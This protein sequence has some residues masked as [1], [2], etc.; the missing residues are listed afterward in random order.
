MPELRKISG[1]QALHTL[2]RLGFRRVRQRGS[3]VVLTKHTPQGKVG[4]AVPMHRE[5]KIGTIKG[6]LRQ[7]GLTVDE[8][9]RAL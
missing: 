9:T 8:F 3:H 4:C 6:I 5:L 7:A 1:R 2:E